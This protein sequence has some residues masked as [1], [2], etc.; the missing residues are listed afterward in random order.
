VIPQTFDEAYERV[1]HLVSIFRQNEKQYLSSAYSEA[2]ARLD[3]ID[4]FWIALGWDVNHETQTNPYEQE[5]KVERGVAMSAGRKR[6]DYAF[7]ASNFR[8]VLFYVEAKKP[9]GELDT[10][11]NYFQTIRYGWSNQTPLAVLTD[12][13]HLRILDCRYRPD[14]ETSIHRAVKKFHYLEYADEDKF[15]EIYYLFSREASIT[16]SLEKYAATLPKPKRKADQRTSISAGIQSIDELFL[17]ELDGY[18]EELARSFKNKNPHLN[19]EELTEVT[20]RT[21]DRLVFM[22]FLEDKLIEPEPLVKNLGVKGT[23][24]QDF[25]STSHRLDGIY[26]GIIFKKHTLLDAPD[27]Q[28]DERTFTGIRDKFAHSNSPYDFNA[29]PIHILGS[30]YERFLGKVIVATDK[31]ARVEEKP[32]VRKAG[33]VYYTPQYIVTYIVDN[34]VGKL[35]ERKTPEE[36]S[37]LRFADI[38]CGSGSFLLGVYDL[39]LR[40]HTAY[41]NE[42]KNRTKAVKAGCVERDDGALHLSL[43]QKKDILLNN[44]YGVDVDGQAVEV[45]QLSL[46]LKLL[47][48]ETTSTAKTHQL[49]FRE[50]MLPTLD[51]NVIHGNALI[52]WNVLGGE[53]FDEEQHKLFP[54]DFED[55]FKDI[56]KSGGFDAIVGNPPYIR[57]QTL[58]E[59]TP[60]AVE[61]FSAHYK[62][63]GKGNYDI[64]VVFVERALSLLNENGK[65]GYI[66]PH[67]FFTAK[68]GE[69][70][71]GHLSA[72]NHLSQIVHFGDQ[73]IFVGATTYTCLLFLE[74][75]ITKQLSF[76]KVHDLNA[77]RETS[78]ALEAT[79]AAS[80]ITSTEWNF[81]VGKGAT[82]FAKL[83]AMPAKLAD[84]ADRIFQGLVTG[85]DLVFILT[86]AGE[87]VYYS[88]ATEQKHEIEQELMHPLCK[89]S[90][91]M[92]RYH[93]NELTKSILFPYKLVDGKAVLLTANELSQRFP[94]AW[95]Y[96]RDNKSILEAR[97]HGKWKHARWYAFGR[98]QNLS[99]MEQTKLL[100]PSI[101]NRASFTLDSDDYYYFV[102]SGGGGGGGY[103]V[104][105]KEDVSLSYEYV[106]GLLNSKLLDA[107][108]KSFSSPFQHGY[109]A[110]NRQYIERL[111]M[112][113]IN[114]ENEADKS[115]HDQ[116]TNLVIQMLESKPQYLSA[117]SDRERT[118]YENKCA[119]LDRQIDALVYE[120]YG[121][122][123]EEIA[124]IEAN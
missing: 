19:S 72:G 89:G 23:A 73:Q 17:Q 53:L 97:E 122:T 123:D 16:G 87:G 88:E 77:W 40:H 5:V 1:K 52:G 9:Q 48:D 13:E 91:N 45:A 69:A 106:L 61:Y 76:V 32:E 7:L 96:F 33:G 49:E 102:G 109:C 82:L 101:A 57:I 110:Y 105:L 67:K 15:R 63:A 78:A 56:M 116:L 103:G 30:I 10:L 113:T 85:A 25:V 51:K 39:L 26:N 22:R 98:S 18:R 50:T 59:T 31:R 117:R 83:G 86:N 119:A 71:R 107:Y 58:Q 121:L 46:F 112:R 104:T 41:Y 95:S 29:I 20:Q 81:N 64:Y 114:V 28:V 79:I 37:K 60:L 43:H 35:I 47:E 68:Y 70:L 42:K 118:F 14:I 75:A 124:L 93:V 65:L 80:Q 111:P 6:A 66:L 21:L 99:E 120:L 115:L 4:K 12:F 38:A 55:K 94:N 54:L 90:V 11:D 84:V 8:D 100:T 108:L 3:F 36:V 2:Q 24:W 74:Q 62:S 44:L 92:R 27:F 34:T